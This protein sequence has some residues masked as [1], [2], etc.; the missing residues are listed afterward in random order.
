MKKFLSVK[1]RIEISERLLPKL[2]EILL[3]KFG[4]NC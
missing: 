1:V 4:K 3:A 2:D